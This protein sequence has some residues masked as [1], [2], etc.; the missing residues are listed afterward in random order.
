[1]TEEDVRKSLEVDLKA[2][3][4]DARVEL[5]ENGDYVVTFAR[6]ERLRT[7]KVEEAVRSFLFW[8]NRC[9]TSCGQRGCGFDISGGYPSILDIVR[10]T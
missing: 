5:V 2:T 1:M 3:R 8:A 6:K 9:C 7:L 4:A 10:A